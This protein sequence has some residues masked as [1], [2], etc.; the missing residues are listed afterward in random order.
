MILGDSHPRHLQGE[1]QEGPRGSG[2][3][4]DRLHTLQEHLHECNQQ[5]KGKGV[6]VAKVATSLTS[7]L[8]QPATKR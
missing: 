2:R 7:S 8:M 3:G 5:Q 6:Y 1:G 4:P